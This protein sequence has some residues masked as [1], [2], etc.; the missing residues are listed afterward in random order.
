MRSMFLSRAMAV[1]FVFLVAGLVG[2]PLAGAAPALAQDY[3]LGSLDIHHPWA[4][5][6]A[7]QTGAAYFIIENKGKAD[8]A[9]VSVESGV[10]DKVQ[11]HDMT[12]DGMVMRMR[13]LE[14]LPLPA[15]Q[16]VRVAPGGLHIMLIGLK[17][18]LK[19]G[20]MFPMRLVFDKAGPIDVSAHVQTLEEMR[21]GEAKAG[22]PAGMSDMPGMA[23]AP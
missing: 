15:G 20:D 17:A 7:G 4:R 2:G 5:P 16:T 21:K 11:I 3:K 13:R 10:A 8:D 14:K 12:M 1:G 9:L 6:S 18:P 19:D 22:M 23:P